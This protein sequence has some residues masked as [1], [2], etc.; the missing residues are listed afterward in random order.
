MIIII[1]L[2]FTLAFCL[3]YYP[4]LLS[5]NPLLHNMGVRGFGVYVG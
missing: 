4:S 3:N 1:I 5:T 2:T